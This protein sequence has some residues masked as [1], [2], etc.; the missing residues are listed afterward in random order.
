MCITMA[1]D[2]TI[3][4][5]GNSMGI[6]LPMEFVRNEG[7]RENKKVSISIIKKADL[8]DVFGLA[9]KRKMSGQKMKNLSRIEWEK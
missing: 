3:K 5:W 9:K 8:S 4:K 1:I 7:L 6:V 2:V